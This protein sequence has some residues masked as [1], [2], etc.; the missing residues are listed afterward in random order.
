MIMQIETSLSVVLIIGFITILIY[1]SIISPK[2]SSSSSSSSIVD[3]L[4][5][6]I[7]KRQVFCFLVCIPPFYTLVLIITR[8][9]FFPGN[10]VT[11]LYEFYR[12]NSGSSSSSSLAQ[13]CSNF[14]EVLPF[15]YH[16]H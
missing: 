13:I 8:I 6:Q 14:D 4:S 5:N 2:T 11:F 10:F 15:S 3:F 16:K 7:I 9:A 12:C 1:Y